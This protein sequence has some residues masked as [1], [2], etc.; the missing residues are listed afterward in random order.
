MLRQQI[1]SNNDMCTGFNRAFAASCTTINAVKSMSTTKT[2]TKTTTTKT[3]KL[4]ARR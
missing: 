3:A 1:L 2:T 4:M